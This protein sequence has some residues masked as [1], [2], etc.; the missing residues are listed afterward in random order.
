M[1]S[2]RFFASVVMEHGLKPL[3]APAVA[4]FFAA[5]AWLAHDR[6]KL[7]IE[8]GRI[9]DIVR[10]ADYWSSEAN[11]KI[12]SRQDVMRAIDE[13]IQRV[14]RL[15]DRGQEIIERGIVL[16]DT[17]GTKVGQVNGLSVLQLGSFASWCVSTPAEA[18]FG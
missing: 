18:P 13:Q 14:D 15:R 10:E 9:S 17:E 1:S 6:E 16:V 4:R 12:T 7:S 3:D 5:G 11:R 2:A 8:L